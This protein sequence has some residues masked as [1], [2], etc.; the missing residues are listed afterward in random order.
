MY[1]AYG[2]NFT[3]TY[4]QMSVPFL[5][6]FTA[7]EM[8]IDTNNGL[9][10]YFAFS[11]SPSKTFSTIYSY[12]MLSGLPVSNQLL[13]L[14]SFPVDPT[15]THFTVQFTDDR[16]FIYQIRSPSFYVYR[17][18]T[19][20]RALIKSQ[21]NLGNQ[22]IKCVAG[23][24]NALWVLFN[25]QPYIQAFVFTVES[26]HIAWQQFFPVLKVELVAEAEQRISIPDTYNLATP[27]WGHT[28]AFGYN[29]LAAMNRDIY[30]IRPTTTQAGIAQWGKESQYQV[31]D[32]SFQGY[33]FNSYLQDLPLQA[34]NTSY[35][36]LRG[37]SPTE[38]FQTQV[39][40]SLPNVYDLG[41][42]T[43]SDIISEI[44][45]LSTS[46]ESFSAIYSKQLSTFNGSFVRSNADALYGISSYSLPTVGFSNFIVQYSTIYGQYTTLKIVTDIINS[47]LRVS[48]NR[49]ILND[50]QYILPSNVLTRTRFTDSLTFSFL[51]KTGLATTPP[52]YANLVDGWGLGW[53]LGYAKEDDTQPSTV[54]FAPSMY[55]IIDDFLYLRLNPEF[56]LN[57]M[58]AG[59]KENYI[60]SREPSGLTSYYYCKLLLNGYGQTATTFVHSPI[61]LNP[62]ITRISKISFQWLD[63]RGNL[64]NIPS[65]TDSDW[66]MT[67]N[68]QESVKTTNFVQTSTVKAKDFLSSTKG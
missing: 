49:F 28:V 62:P 13:E 20:T 16:E 24:N 64:L 9:N 48:M 54:H 29:S 53:N 47:N 46:P 2:T 30:Y 34:S 31:S 36:A 6:L 18:D 67:V 35:V 27:E 26:V 68:I 42:A 10:V 56:N 4:S 12:P 21:Q 37:F 3:D 59:T 23:T 51:W 19:K 41:Y 65:A 58:S 22:P 55:K 50:M 11:T 66:Q 45:T 63:A 8:C 25:Q 44:A 14:K 1:I 57:R 17:T 52:N 32:T 40:V 60:D 7:V 5:G 38:S 39:R 15:T 43:F 61:L 33:Y